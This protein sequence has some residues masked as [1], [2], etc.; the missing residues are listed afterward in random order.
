MRIL[1]GVD[2][3]EH[4]TGA[5]EFVCRHPLT[6]AAA[7]VT[8]VFV[9]GLT[10]LQVVAVLGRRGAA[11]MPVEAVP[12]AQP[13]L[14]TLPQAGIEVS[15]VELTGDAGLDIHPIV[16]DGNCNLTV[17]GSHGRGPHK[18]AVPG[19]VVRKVPGHCAVPAPFAHRRCAAWHARRR[20]S[21]RQPGHKDRAGRD[22]LLRVRR[23]RAHRQ[24]AINCGERVDHG[25]LD[26][27]VD[28]DQRVRHLAARLVDH[29]VDVQS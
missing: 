29:V 6:T 10:P 12:A 27:A 18:R 3:S 28:V 7:Q 11:P 16:R 4:A 24:H 5:V 9:T 23:N 13:A 26:R 21:K 15:R 20:S 8:V 17:I 22:S 14:D 1:I 25:L 2:G 19:T